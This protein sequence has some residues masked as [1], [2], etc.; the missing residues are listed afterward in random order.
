MENGR[1]IKWT[2]RACLLGK[3]EG[4]LKFVFLDATKVLI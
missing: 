2:V 1:K 4:N 3:M